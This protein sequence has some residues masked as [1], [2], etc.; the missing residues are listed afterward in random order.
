M[1]LIFKL[2]IVNDIIIFMETPLIN[3]VKLVTKSIFFIY[4]SYYKI[5][6]YDISYI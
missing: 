6:M 2:L 5:Y 1:N 4:I 3:D